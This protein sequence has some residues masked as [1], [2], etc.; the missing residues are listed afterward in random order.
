MVIYGKGNAVYWN[1][2]RL[3]VLELVKG[4]VFLLQPAFK[5]HFLIQIINY[6]QVNDI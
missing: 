6:S 3:I 5:L 1:G 2:E 4:M